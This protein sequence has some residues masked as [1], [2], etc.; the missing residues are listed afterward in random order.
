MAT[1]DPKFDLDKDGEIFG[2]DFAIFAMYI[3]TTVN[4]ND[5]MSV[6]C[7]FNKDGV[8]DE[9]DF[10]LFKEHYQTKGDPYPPVGLIPSKSNI[11]WIILGISLAYLMF[12]RKRKK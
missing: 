6:A 8:V 11:A 5:P 4:P 12:L 1:Y 9:K 7:D 10:E 3:D 2:S